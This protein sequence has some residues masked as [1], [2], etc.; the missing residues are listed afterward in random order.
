M[1]EFFFGDL[2]DV[3]EVEFGEEFF[4]VEEVGFEGG[5]G[6]VWGGEGG[7]GDVGGVG[8]WWGFG[9]RSGWDY[10]GGEVDDGYGG[11]FIWGWGGWGNEG[12]ELG[13]GVVGVVGEWLGWCFGWGF[14]VVY[15]CGFE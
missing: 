4:V 3:G 2:F 10:W 9:W 8:C 7:V 5:G 13:E 14:G 6:W 12:L 1:Y 15:F 11:F